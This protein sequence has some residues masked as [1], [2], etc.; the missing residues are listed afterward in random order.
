MN[1][2]TEVS[3]LYKGLIEA[4]SDIKS[5][6]KNKQGY[7]YKYATLD[8]IIDMLDDALPKHG[9]G[10]S[11]W[12]TMQNDKQAL[13]TRVFHISG[14]WMEDVVE[15]TDTEL[16]GKANATQQ[17][18]ASITY[19]RRYALSAIFGI[20][21]DEDVDGMVD[22]Q[23]KT[24]IKPTPKPSVKKQEP[25]PY[26]KADMDKRVSEG[27]TIESV[28][29]DYADILQTDKINP[30]SDMSDA[31]KTAVA[32]ALWNRNKKLQQQGEKAC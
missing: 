26:I 28:L 29:K 20:A 1:T 3:N 16:S 14:E 10:Y 22:K 24:A 30:V 9:L 25:E 13:L 6:P 18:G 32:R 27:E 7:G 4:R 23:P 21:S 15:M 17:A 5:V 2:S 19:Y 31:E 8:S 12:V 11:Q